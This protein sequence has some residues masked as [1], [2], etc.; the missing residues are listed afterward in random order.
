[1]PNA[2]LYLHLSP[3]G[4]LP[5]LSL[6]VF[7]AVIIIDTDVSEQWRTQVSNWIV[8]SGCLY[9]MAW[10]RDCSAWDD[11]VDIANCAHFN[12]EGIPDES[13]ITTTWHADEPL[14]ETFWYCKHNAVHSHRNLSHTLLLHIADLAD[15]AQMLKVYAN[16]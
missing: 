6:P 11:S 2:P 9:M 10:G 7:R 8:R 15:E 4:R 14:C 13:F 3:E 16:A 5:E 1:M 12:Y